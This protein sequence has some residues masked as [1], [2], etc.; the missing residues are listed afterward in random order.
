[1]CYLRLR[2]ICRES[3]RPAGI[4]G[5]GDRT[6]GEGYCPLTYS[7]MMPINNILWQQVVREVVMEG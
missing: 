5:F 2:L 1:M 7:R 6:V 4:V 3:F